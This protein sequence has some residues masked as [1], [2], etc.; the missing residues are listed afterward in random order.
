MDE[1]RLLVLSAILFSLALLA[2]ATIQS[3]ASA[4]G[5][6]FYVSPEGNDLNPGTESRP[7]ATISRGVS[8]LGP[9]DTLV[10]RGGTYHEAIV[11]NV[12]GTPDAP[13]EIKGAEGEVVIVDA[14]GLGSNGITLAPGVSHVRILNLRVLGADVWCISLHGGNSH[15]HLEEVEAADCEVGIHMTTGYSGQQPANGPVDNVTVVRSLIHDNLYSGI[16]CTPGPCSDVTVAWSSIYGNGAEGG[17]GADGIGAESGERWAVIGCD[18]H[19]NGGDGVDLGSRNSLYGIFYAGVVDRCKVH[20]NGMEGVKLW[21]SGY[22]QNT[23][24][25]RNGLTGIDL[26][27]SGEYM[28]LNSLVAFNSIENRAYSLVAGYPEPEPLAP[29]DDLRV[30]VYS[31]IFAFNGPRDEPV[32]IYIGAGVEFVEDHN[33]WYSRADSEIWLEGE[34]RDVTREDIASGAWT[35]AT[36]N[37]AHSLTVDPE[38][39]DPES[40]DYHLSPGSPAIDAGYLERYTPLDLDSARRPVGDGPDIGP[41]EFGGQPPGTPKPPMSPAQP[42]PGGVPSSTAPPATEPTGAATSSPTTEPGRASA[43]GLGG[44]TWAILGAA[45]L[46]SALAALALLRRRGGQGPGKADHRSEVLK[47]LEERYRRGEI[48]EELYRELRRKYGGGG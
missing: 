45:A 2:L 38:F 14:S 6:T 18:I 15:V 5:R 11:I 41:Y 25:Y 47:K 46:A 43:G 28:V 7:W 40:D 3:E 35:R 29:Q 8:E 12:S 33:I 21:T 42:G 36:G 4:R 30:R 10:I 22:V 44:R 32:G 39:V 27:Y 13:I 1:R 16:D 34:Q 24:I 37:G 19:H 48:P 9:G 31:S 26:V 20:H 23:A 17:F